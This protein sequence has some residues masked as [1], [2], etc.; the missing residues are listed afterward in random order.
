MVVR[1][2]SMVLCL[3]VPNAMAQVDWTP[4]PMVPAPE[5]PAPQGLPP[6]PPA[7]PVAQS[8]PTAAP[9][10]ATLAERNAPEIGLMVSEALFGMLTAA[11]VSVLPYFLL[12]AS[13]L[14]TNNVVGA[15]LLIAIFSA[16]PLA[17]AQTQTSIANGSR[18][19]YS[20]MWPAALAG[21]A[22]QAAVLGLFYATGW[23]PS[24]GSNIGGGTGSGVPKASGSAALLLLGTAV[25]VPLLQMAVINLTKQPK[26]RTNDAPRPTVAPSLSPIVTDA[27]SGPSL[28]AQLG[29]SGTF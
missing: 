10:A 4:P 7:P 19:Y 21:L 18:W 15:V 25:V 13:G 8:Q 27:R 11:G 1:A 12:D 24:S 26:F 28:G 17:V 2:L 6:P 20:E 5:A 22:G 29:L 3:A 9:S 16:V 14:L 23:L